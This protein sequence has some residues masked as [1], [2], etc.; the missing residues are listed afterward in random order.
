MNV[1]GKNKVKRGF[2]R[3]FTVLLCLFAGASLG[4]YIGLNVKNFSHSIS[5]AELQKVSTKENSAK[6]T[7]NIVIEL[8]KP[9][10]NLNIEDIKIIDIHKNNLQIPVLDMKFSD[11]NKIIDVTIIPSNTNITPEFNHLDEARVKIQNEYYHTNELTVKLSKGDLEEVKILSLDS[12]VDGEDKG[13]NGWL[14]LTLSKPIIGLNENDIRIIKKSD[15]IN[16]GNNDT[17]NHT[18]NLSSNGSTTITVLEVEQNVKIPNMYNL[19]ILGNY[20]NNDEVIVDIQNDNYYVQRSIE[21]VVKLKFNLNVHGRARMVP[22]GDS[23]FNRQLNHQLKGTTVVN[24][25][26]RSPNTTV[27]VQ[28]QNAI[29]EHN[30]LTWVNADHNWHLRKKNDTSSWTYQYI[31][32]T[33]KDVE[34]GLYDV[35]VNV[36]ETFE[37]TFEVFLEAYYVDDD[38]QVTTV[39]GIIFN[40]VPTDENIDRK[41]LDIIYDKYGNGTLVGIKLEEIVANKENENFTTLL[42][43]SS[44][45]RITALAYN[46]LIDRPKMIAYYFNSS[47]NNLHDPWVQKITDDYYSNEEFEKN[48]KNFRQ[49]QI[50]KINFI[51]KMSLAKPKMLHLEPYAFHSLTCENILNLENAKVEKIDNF[52]LRLGDRGFAIKKDNTDYENICFDGFDSLISIE[53]PTRW[54]VNLSFFN[55]PKLTVLKNF[56]KEVKI[57]NCPALDLTRC[58]S[59]TIKQISE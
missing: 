2:I 4:A 57:K 22:I 52:S 18:K 9:I 5:Q 36:P 42:I 25:V 21:H 37:N 23:L 20:N 45:S 6:V 59:V 56:T 12:T 53:N 3:Y 10:S 24:G 34:N 26:E 33:E 48:C 1:E 30:T 29:E 46:P 14:N 54:N 51:T 31:T 32:V 11:S 13:C 47:L 50:N 16:I 17:A 43:P 58:V 28:L 49:K 44:V 40:P 19:R 55:C 15:F 7:T 39:D 38:T 41:Y 8:T 35:S 27:T